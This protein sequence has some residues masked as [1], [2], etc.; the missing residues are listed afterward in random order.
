[1]VRSVSL[2][3]QTGLRVQVWP[4]PNTRLE[5]RVHYTKRVYCTRALTVIDITLAFGAV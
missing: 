1:M 5:T 3:P 2:Y 4:A